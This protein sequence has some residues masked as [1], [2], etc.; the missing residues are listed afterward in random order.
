MERV[1]ILVTSASRPE[2]LKQTIETLKRHLH[3]SGN[4]RWLLHED[5]VRN[6]ESLLC[7]EWAM[8]NGFD[9][10]KMTYPAERQGQS[11]LN[12]MNMSDSKY[13]V[14]TED[15]WVLKK[16]INLDNVLQVLEKDKEIAIAARE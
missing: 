10:I 12:L 8:E 3:Y 15:D 5:V 16:D 11:V 1:D 13:F 4:L 6:K 9:K 7:V 2:Y 14:R